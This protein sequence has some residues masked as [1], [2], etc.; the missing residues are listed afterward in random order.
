LSKSNAL[1]AIICWI[2]IINLANI[3][4]FSGSGSFFLLKY[5]E[6]IIVAYGTSVILFENTKFL[7]QILAIFLIFGT[8][9]SIIAIF[10]FIY[11]KSLGLNKLGEQIIG[12]NIDG[13]AKI[14]V[15]GQK[16]IRSYG[17]FPHPNLLSAFLFT[18]LLLNLW[19]FLKTDHSIQKYILSTTLVINCFGLL[20][21]FSRAAYLALAI[22]L[23]VFFGGYFAKKIN[24]K[25][26]ISAGLIIIIS[27]GLGLV[28][29]KPY[30]L[31]RTTVS[32]YSSKERIFY[33]KIGANI[34]KDHPLV[35]VGFG[36]SIFLMQKYSPVKLWP[37]EIQPIH[38]Y[39]LLA[40]AEMGIIGS[41]LLFIF[42]LLH[43]KQL[44]KNIHQKR[45][46]ASLQITLVSILIGFLILM[47]F[48]HYFYTIEQTQLLLWIILGIINGQTKISPEEEKKSA[49]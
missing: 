31:T 47:Q 26:L 42:F 23:I 13:V 44:L 19:F 29:L 39:F 45:R 5:L 22:G 14:I 10:Q 30:L 15:N 38:N 1:I 27:L 6:L 49:P 37:W 8:F 3:G 34:I 2:I 12:P 16:F 28:M 20:L 18:T 36:Q 24:P 11:Q 32:D 40:A 41:M 25:K 21:T 43:V 17:T 9:E 33:A 48:D 4:Y 7:E 46:D 35:G